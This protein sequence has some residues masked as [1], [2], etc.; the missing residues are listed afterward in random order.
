MYSYFYCL[1]NCFVCYFFFQQPVKMLNL[2]KAAQLWPC[3][4]TFCESII[5]VIFFL[6]FH[7]PFFSF[8]MMTG[9]RGVTQGYHLVIILVKEVQYRCTHLLTILKCRSLSHNC[10]VSWTCSGKLGFYASFPLQLRVAITNEAKVVEH[11]ICSHARGPPP[12]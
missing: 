6:Y 2:F 8:F 11:V 7:Y 12:S 3:K 1:I 5:A 10:L 4:N 9:S